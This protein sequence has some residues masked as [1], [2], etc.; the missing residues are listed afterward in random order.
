MQLL[1]DILE[2]YW[3][4]RV[5]LDVK[6]VWKLE[7]LSTELRDSNTPK[8]KLLHFFFYERDLLQITGVAKHLYFENICFNFSDISHP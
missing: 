2:M 4:Y 5:I 1:W 7:R 8:S 6:L 3:K